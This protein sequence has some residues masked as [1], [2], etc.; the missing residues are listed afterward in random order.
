MCKSCVTYL[1][2]YIQSRP[3]HDI[4]SRPANDI[5]SRPAHDI[6]PRPA[7][8]IPS[9]PAHDIQSRPAHDIPS[10]PAHDI[11]SRPAHDIQSRPALNIHPPP[12]SLM[13]STLAIF[14]TSP[15]LW[16]P[17]SECLETHFGHSCVYWIKGDLN[18]KPM[19]A[20]LTSRLLP[21]HDRYY[22]E[23]FLRFHWEWKR[24]KLSFP[25]RD[26]SA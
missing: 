8:D 15:S 2:T 25:G 4:P 20:F 24:G 1:L 18:R 6:Q 12:Y 11:Q 7:H 10:R 14:M 26:P 5:Q 21:N 23:R 3:A 17:R 16:H 9:R 19:H 22:M 13:P